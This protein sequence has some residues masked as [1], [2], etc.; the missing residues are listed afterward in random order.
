MKKLVLVCALALSTLTFAQE[1]KEKQISPE[2]KVAAQIK[3][4]D[5]DL[6]LSDDQEAKLKVILLEQQK[7]KESLKNLT[8]EEK[9][10]KKKELRQER[11]VFKNK[12][13]EI[14]TPEQFT[15]WQEKQIEMAKKGKEKHNSEE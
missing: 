8:E 14:L 13:K 9:K 4:M 2:K 11:E 6:N 5:Q 1:K 15:K 7:H 10:A 3:K 12:V